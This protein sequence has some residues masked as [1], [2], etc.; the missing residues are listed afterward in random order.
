MQGLARRGEIEAG[1]FGAI[2]AGDCAR[3]IRRLGTYG[4]RSTNGARP[5]R[6]CNSAGCNSASGS[7]AYNHTA[8]A[9]CNSC[10]R[11]AAAD[12]NGTGA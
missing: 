12:T 8:D 4:W 1:T 10:T 3:G 5:G 11:Y 6:P 9:S 2:E 7:A